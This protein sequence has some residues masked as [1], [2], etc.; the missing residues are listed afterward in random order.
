MP[1][2]DMRVGSFKVPGK[3]GMSTDVSVVP[4]AGVG[5]NDLGNIN[6]WRGQLNLEPIAQED[7]PKHISDILV[8][9]RHMHFVNFVSRDPILDK[10]HKQR[11]MAAYYHDGERTWFFKMTGEDSNVSAAKP[12]FMKLLASIRL[13][14]DTHE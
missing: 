3:N 9:T 5:G 4:L 8:G 11:M 1:P 7:L 6:R 2:S 14:N 13:Q 12:S 10:T